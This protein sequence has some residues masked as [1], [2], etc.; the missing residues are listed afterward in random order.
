MTDQDNQVPTDASAQP[1]NEPPGESTHDAPIEAPVEEKS[2]IQNSSDPLPYHLAIR[3]YLIEN[4]KQVWDWFVKHKP[5]QKKQ[6]KSEQ[7]SDESN[8]N[9]TTNRQSEAI[10]LDLLKRTYRVD[11]EA[12]PD[13]YKL[14]SE[15]AAQLDMDVPVTI[16][17][18]Q[19]PIGLNAS[20]AYIPGEAHIV[21]H[22]PISTQLSP[23][24]QR[25][26]LAHELGHLLLLDQSSNEILVTEQVLS[27]MTHDQNADLSHLNTARLFGLYTEVF[28][29]RVAL[30]VV[31]DPY[32]VISMLV[33][34]VTG[35][36]DV[37]AKSYLKQAKEIMTAGTITSE[38]I[39]HPESYIRALVT[40]L[41]HE[42]GDAAKDEVEAL[43][44]GN[45]ALDDLD[46][47]AR[48]KL[49]GFTKDL[50]D[51]TLAPKWT[52]T[53]IML[54][55]AKLFFDGY[56]PP[57]TT[58]R[59]KKDSAKKDSAKKSDET[60]PG[61]TQVK[62]KKT[63]YTLD[64]IK[65]ATQTA[66]AIEKLRSQISIRHQSVQDYFCFI[67]LDFA[68]SDKD[69]EEAALAHTLDVAEQLGLGKRFSELATKELRLRKKQLEKISKDRMILIEAAVKE[70][71]TS[72]S[73]EAQ[74]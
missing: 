7:P 15:V 57:K 71:V 1:P 4:E 68:A 32:V 74:K 62:E 58:S 48:Q 64:K 50:I 23:L 11:R 63:K 60:L 46:V 38:G 5:A 49:V 33:K 24:E 30:R 39:S 16:Y 22:G 47:L 73:S 41:W 65:S 27:A 26:L 40:H 10:R 67:L 43:I 29:D 21:L 45:P 59:S 52:Q 66:T 72:S 56:K 3:D 31:N 9:K 42:K 44:A 55:H 28:C 13:I 20:L 70:S 14:A 36:E 61:E 2:V 6:T 34:V 54:S 51:V 8:K 35:I 19:N 17:Q 53:D 69:L 12:Q 18:A 37:D 25:A